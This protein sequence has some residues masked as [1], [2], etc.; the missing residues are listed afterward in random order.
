MCVCSSVVAKDTLLQTHTC[1]QTSMLAIWFLDFNVPSVAYGCLW[2]KYTFEICL[3]QFKRQ[4]TKLQVKVESQFWTQHSQQ[5]PQPGHKWSVHTHM[6]TH[7]DTHIHMHVHTH[8][9]THMHTH[10]PTHTHPFYLTHAYITPPHTHTHTHSHPYP[11]THTH[12]HTTHT[13]RLT[14]TQGCIIIT[15]WAAVVITFTVL[16]AVATCRI[17]TKGEAV[18]H[19]TD[20]LSMAWAHLR[21][22]SATQNK[23]PK[24][25]QYTSQTA[26]SLCFQNKPK[27]QNHLTRELIS[28]CMTQVAYSNSDLVCV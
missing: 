24:Q 19:T 12:T 10:K 15:P 6:D 1:T 23:S 16:P 14:S 11:H 7:T 26:A 8:T 2:M 9:H 21:V 4:V 13:Q 20:T 28:T 3:Y 22:I 5:Q 17:W 25:I 27:Q 18:A